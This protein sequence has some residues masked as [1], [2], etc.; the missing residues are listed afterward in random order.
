MTDM[1]I[2]KEE[3][4][5]IIIEAVIYVALIILSSYFTIFGDIFIRMVPMLYFLGILG[6]IMFDKPIVTAILGSVSIFTFGCLVE[7]EIN[8][9]IVL[10]AIYSAFMIIFGEVTGHILNTLYENAKLRKFIK[11]YHK[12]A[13]I[14]GLVLCI[15]IP[16]ILNNIVNSN[17]VSY[18][19]ARKNI[20]KYISENY[21]YSEQYMKEINYLPSYTGGIYEFNAVIDGLEVKLNYNKNGEIADV[22]LDSRKI[23][24]NKSINA[25]MNIL[26]KENNL[27][28]LDVNCRYEYS[29]V[30]TIPD[31]I[32]INVDDVKE[33]QIDNLLKFIQALKTWD[34]FDKIDR[35]DISVGGINVSISKKD[36]NEKEITKD[37][38]L[39]G[40][41]QEILDSKE[42]Q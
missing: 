4:I 38:I 28:N 25:E 29:K 33:S 6:C 11:Y 20:D 34:K 7:S 3:K 39:N 30:A 12:I 17:I 10:L 36:L 40:M 9:S 1:F 21:A 2:T 24:L 42:D 14:V 41:K 16:L 22:N 8:M 31:I 37:F 15:L 26:L 32:R 27:A 35:V 19:I 18:M 13:Y 23:T 5:K